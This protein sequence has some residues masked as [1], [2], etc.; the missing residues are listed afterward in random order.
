MKISKIILSVLFAAYFALAGTGFNIINFC[1]ERCEDEGVAMLMSH[2]CSEQKDEQPMSC[3]KSE[4]A[5]SDE[6]TCS[7]HSEKHCKIMR[8]QVETPSFENENVS[9]VLPNFTQIFFIDNSLFFDELS[10]ETSSQNLNSLHPKLCFTG[11]DVLI[12][13]A[14]L[15]I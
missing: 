13:K 14:V 5:H 12:R 4:K 7:E 11:R 9:V 1:C 6:T 15:L 10:A 3:C 8:L 2:E